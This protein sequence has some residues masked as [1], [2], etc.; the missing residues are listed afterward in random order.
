MCDSPVR[1]VLDT[2][3]FVAAY[4]A[5][6]SAS[7]M[8]IQAC[9][10]G[11]ARAAYTR[12]A[13]REVEHILRQIRLPERYFDYLEQ[14]WSA[15]ELVAARR[16]D[17]IPVDDPDDRKFLEAAAGANADFLATNDDHLLSVGY[18]GR[19]EILSPGSLAKI[20]NLQRQ[21]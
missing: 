5:P 10:D 11:A 8:L 16:V 4:W 7:A 2:N 3:V 13:R 20:L 6:N 1:V 19:T 18:V 9:I 12:E 14:Y 17:D 21:M 15:A